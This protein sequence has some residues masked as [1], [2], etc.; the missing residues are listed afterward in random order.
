ML[1]FRDTDSHLTRQLDINLWYLSI[2][3]Q[4]S[5]RIL[6]IGTDFPALLVQEAHLMC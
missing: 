3:S 4:S 5:V 6:R 2:R 1:Y